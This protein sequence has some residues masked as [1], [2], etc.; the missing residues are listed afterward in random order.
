MYPE[1]TPIERRFDACVHVVGLCA[2]IAAVAALHSSLTPQLPLAAGVCVA[3]YTLTLI[4]MIGC[5]AAY[6]MLPWPSWKDFLRRADHAAI[7]LKIAGTYTP[8]AA[9]K[10][11]GFASTA[12]LAIVW[13]VALSGAA[14]KIL[15]GKQWHQISLWLY[16]ALGWVGLM[17]F[18]SLV[19]NV[20]LSVV[21]L[22]GVGGLAYSL[23]VIFHVWESLPFQNAIW[24]VFVLIG[25]CCH[26]GAVTVA[27][28]T[29]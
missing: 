1:Y 14:A 8:F 19:E 28:M 12:L 16:L 5:S 9:I 13:C 24:H 6:H 3:I 22:L 27:V 18:P 21:I 4:A 15:V 11:T 2:S 29:P 26:F 25:T 23:G 7:F 10:M 17:F 20:D